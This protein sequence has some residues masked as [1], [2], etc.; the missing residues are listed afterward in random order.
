MMPPNGSIA[1]ECRTD[2]AV[3]QPLWRTYSSWPFYGLECRARG[4]TGRGC[5]PRSHGDLVPVADRLILGHQPRPR[6]RP[7]GRAPADRLADAGPAPRRPR[8]AAG[9]P[10]VAAVRALRRRPGGPP[11]P[12]PH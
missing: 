6:P 9:A 3:A 4:P 10:A 1:A 2:P 12:T 5:P 8:R 11:R 7:R